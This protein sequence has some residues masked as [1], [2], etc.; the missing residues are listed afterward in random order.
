MACDNCQHLKVT[1]FHYEELVSRWNDI[2]NP[3]YITEGYRNRYL[4]E[5]NKLGKPFGETKLRFTYCDIGFLNRFYIVRG[6]KVVRP[7]ASL[8]QCSSYK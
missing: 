1:T 6:A 5:S 8:G 3:M 4:R 7:K 2:Y